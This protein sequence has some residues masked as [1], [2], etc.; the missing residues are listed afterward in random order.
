VSQIGLQ[1]RICFGY[2]DPNV[3]QAQHLRAQPRRSALEQV[4][5]SRTIA[6]HEVQVPSRNVDGSR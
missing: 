6:G 4:P 1:E 5:A 2:R 3:S